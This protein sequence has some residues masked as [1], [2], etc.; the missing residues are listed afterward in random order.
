MGNLNSIPPPT[1]CLPKGLC[2]VLGLILSKQRHQEDKRAP[3]IKRLLP[4]NRRLSPRNSHLGR[5]TDT[6][7]NR[8]VCVF[9][10]H[11]Q[12]YSEPLLTSRFSFSAVVFF[13]FFF[14]WWLK[15]QHNF[16]VQKDLCFPG[17][18]EAGLPLGRGQSSRKTH[19]LWGWFYLFVF[20]ASTPAPPLL[21]PRLVRIP[22]A[23]SS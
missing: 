11:C 3:D 22:G 2:P 17:V 15:Q 20:L 12:K 9:Q 1:P 23:S 6:H 4:A 8:D 14:W 10:L 5:A 13:V 19:I 21:S 18:T 16:H 7:G